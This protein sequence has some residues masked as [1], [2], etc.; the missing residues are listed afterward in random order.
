MATPDQGREARYQQAVHQFETDPKVVAAAQAYG[1]CLRQHG[2]Q[3][4][5]T[6][7]G[8]IEN[9]VQDAV[10][11]QRGQL[12]EKIDAATAQRGLQDEIKKS[13]EDLDCGRDYE[14]VAKPFK[15]KMAQEGVG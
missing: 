2:H 4:A 8:T 6:K 15:D 9:A 3:V 11:K 12:P 7:P 1:T 14:T 13:L 5:S 10:Q